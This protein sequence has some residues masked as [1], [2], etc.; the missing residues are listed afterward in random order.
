MRL[1]RYCASLLLMYEARPRSLIVL[2]LPAKLYRKNYTLQQMGIELATC[3]AIA[4]SGVTLLLSLLAIYWMQLEISSMW[5]ELDAEIDQFKYLTN[6]SW[7]AMVTLGVGTPSNRIRRQSQYG[8]YA[9]VGVNTQSSEEDAEMLPRIM[10]LAEPQ[11]MGMA[12][13]H[14]LIYSTC[15][16][17][18]PGPPGEPGPDGPDGLDGVDGVDG[19]DNMDAMK[20]SELVGCITCPAGHPGPQG[21]TGPPG[22]RGMRGARGIPGVPGRDGTPG[23]PGEQGPPGSPGPDGPPGPPGPK[24]EDAEQPMSRKG[25]RGPPGEPGEQGPPGYPGRN[26]HIGPM[27]PPGMDGVQGYQGAAGPDG[28]P[29]PMGPPGNPGKDATYCNCPRRGDPDGPPRNRKRLRL[30]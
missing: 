20:Y 12:G 5:S 22:V 29:G 11:F 1:R 28:E 6:D 14:C 18:P 23:M 8:G 26:M 4:A 27:G 19:L 7:K 30:V 3:G 17:G 24:G 10:K 2:V 15:P 16:P 9:A 13:C 25:P 21:K